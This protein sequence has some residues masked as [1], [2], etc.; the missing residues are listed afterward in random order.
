M[1]VRAIR[2]R[3]FTPNEKLSKFV[4]EHLPKLREGDVVVVTSKIVALAQGRIVS[5]RTP[6]E[7]ERWIRRGSSKTVRTPWCFLT[8]LNGEW[9]ASAGV[10]ESNADGKLILFPENV[11]REAQKLRLSLCRSFGIKKLG[12]ILTDT[13]LIPMRKGA[14]GV[15]VAFSG[16]EP[17]R[18]YIGKLDLFGRQLKMTQTATVQPLAAAAV[19]AMGEGDEQKPLALIRHAFIEFT[20][21]SI[22]LESLI[23]DPADD[24]Y[25]Y[26]YS[27][28]V[29]RSRAR[30]KPRRSVR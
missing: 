3:L 21:R 7:K 13:R 26:A 11:Q 27:A 22:S 20:K 25:G 15:A 6:K 12:V 17:I 19:F 9:C 30:S 10:D 28:S 24:L 16:I 8:R 4:I 18:N 2:T 14:M 1:D 29:R 5:I 23:V